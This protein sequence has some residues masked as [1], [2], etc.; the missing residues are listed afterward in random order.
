MLG[1][2]FVV[3]FIPPELLA[4]VLLYPTM[5][6]FFQSIPLIIP[7]DKKKILPMTDILGIYRIEITLGHAHVVD[8]IQ[9]V[10]LSGTVIPHKTIY[11]LA[12]FKLQLMVILEV[13]KKNAVEVH[14][15]IFVSVKIAKAD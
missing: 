6:F 1:K 13:N 7:L 12:E 2:P 5:D 9:K 3:L 15:V 8:G 11:L 4:L 14:K 10:G